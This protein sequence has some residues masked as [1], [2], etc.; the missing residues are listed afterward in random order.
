MIMTP[1]DSHVR[2]NALMNYDGDETC[3]CGRA[4]RFNLPAQIVLSEWHSRDTSKSKVQTLCSAPFE[5]PLNP[6]WSL[7]TRECV[8][9]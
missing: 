1:H 2:C 9:R 3:V 8:V 7:C 6:L 4:V 5:D